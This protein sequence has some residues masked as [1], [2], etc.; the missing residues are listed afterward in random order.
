ML[1]TRTRVRRHVS[2]RRLFLSSVLSVIF[3]ALAIMLLLPTRLAMKSTLEAPK[4]KGLF[5]AAGVGLRGGSKQGKGDEET[6]QRL[7]QESLRILECGDDWYRLLWSRPG[8][9]TESMLGK[10][11]NEKEDQL[12][13]MIRKMKAEL[14]PD[15]LKGAPQY[16]T[17]AAR[18]AFERL[19]V[20]QKRIEGETA[21][22]ASDRSD[23]EL[24]K[25]IWPGGVV[26]R[27]QHGMSAGKV[28]V[29][30]EGA[31]VHVAEI[32]GRRAHIVE[33]VDGWLSIHRTDGKLLMKPYVLPMLDAP[34]GSWLRRKA[35]DRKKQVTEFLERFYHHP[36]THRTSMVVPMDSATK[37]LRHRQGESRNSASGTA[38]VDDGE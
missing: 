35:D 14:H 37:Q 18:K 20:A 9:E 4:I 5:S 23:T 12:I 27:G 19:N 24:Y 3:P 8:A 29:L 32:R 30:R 7:Y 17:M 2:A 6:Y 33:P 28:A 25:V 21:D 31:I 16:L 38:M 11:E 22:F 15:R 1:W 10:D 34:E 26:V 36:S 13:A